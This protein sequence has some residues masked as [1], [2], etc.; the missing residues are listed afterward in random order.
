MTMD[1]TYEVV[2]FVRIPDPGSILMLL[3]VFRQYPEE[4]VAIVF[5]PRVV[6]LSASLYGSDFKAIRK[7][8]DMNDMAVPIRGE[9]MKSPTWDNVPAKLKKW[10]YVDATMSEPSVREDTR[11][12]MKAS[13]HQLVAA[14]QEHG[15]GFGRYAIFFDVDSKKRP[16]TRHA[17]QVP[18]FTYN[19]SPEEMQKY[20]EVTSLY[21]EPQDRNLR[22]TL[23]DLINTYIERQPQELELF[24]EIHSFKK[25]LLANK[26]QVATMI[27]SGPFTEPLKYL[28][29]TPPPERILAVG[30]SSDSC[31][32]GTQFDFWTDFNAAKELLA[33]VE[34]KKISLRLIPVECVRRTSDRCPFYLSCSTYKQIL[35]HDSML[36][37]MITR[38]IKN[39]DRKRRYLALDWCAAITLTEPDLF[40]WENVKFTVGK[41]SDRRTVKFRTIE[42]NNKDSTIWIAT[43]DYPYLTTKRRELKINMVKTMKTLLTLMRENA[44]RHEEESEESEDSEYEWGP[45]IDRRR[46]V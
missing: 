14:L 1:V 22:K 12:C 29:K 25:L 24:Q 39:T 3:E 13:C 38:H 28:E 26:T 45:E 18:D 44:R 19:F 7:Y 9:D 4:K 2:V 6:D 8:V 10:F 15:V 41:T 33:Q 5:Y 30:G 46:S 43:D 23:R 16:D 31:D 27:I 40:R 37:R 17:S 32:N 42:N 34:K 20:R 36:Y 11:L 21:R 35:G